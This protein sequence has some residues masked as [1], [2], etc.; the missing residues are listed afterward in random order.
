MPP[1]RIMKK[2]LQ[3]DPR[4]VDALL[5]LAAIAQKQGR[6]GDADRLH[7]TALEAD[8]GMPPPWRR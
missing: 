2:A 4:N 1:G 3:A 7:Q 8:P 6:G 5:G